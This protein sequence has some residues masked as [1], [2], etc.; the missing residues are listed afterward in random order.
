M[1]SYWLKSAAVTLPAKTTKSTIVNA[2]SRTILPHTFQQRQIRP[3]E[4]T[5]RSRRAAYFKCA[6]SIAHV[7]GIALPIGVKLASISARGT[8]SI[9]FCSTWVHKN[10]KSNRLGELDER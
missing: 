9:R 8:F 5:L 7:A 2:D 1:K 3:C 4:T 10:D 6:V